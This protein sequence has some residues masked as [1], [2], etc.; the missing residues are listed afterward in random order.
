MP[1][2]STVKQY[3]FLQAVAHGK[4][5]KKTNLTPAQA[6]AGIMELSPKKR[7]SYASQMSAKAHRKAFGG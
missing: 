3:G 5:R 4:A 7:S 2:P 1:K 6:R